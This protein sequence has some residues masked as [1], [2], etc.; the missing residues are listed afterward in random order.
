MS[1][2]FLSTYIVLWCFVLIQ[3]FALAALYHHFGS[4]ALNSRQGREAQ[5]PELD[6]P[7]EFE[8]GA[9]VTLDGHMT[10]IIELNRPVLLIFVS[11]ACEP[12]AGLRAHVSDFAA[13]SDT[14]IIVLCAGPDE[15]TVISWS[16]LLRGPPIAVVYDKRQR[17]AAKLGVNV[18][19]FLVGIDASEIVRV[20]GIVND[21]AGLIRSASVVE[22]SDHP[23]ASSALTNGKERVSQA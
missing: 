9:L 16:E 14:R 15:L 17:I 20:K 19:P 13:H 7:L 23:A 4:M 12:C 22:E 1:E 21:S 5:G 2:L 3:M 11:T 6:T 8:P 18:T 10:S